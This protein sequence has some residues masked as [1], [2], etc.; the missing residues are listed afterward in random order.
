M[1]K[2]EL[3]AALQDATIDG[4]TERSHLVADRLL[5][6]YIDDQEIQDAW[7]HVPKWYS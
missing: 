6:R 2:D 1:T 4:D 7:D 5:L 3:I